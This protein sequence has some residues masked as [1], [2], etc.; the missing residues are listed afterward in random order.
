MDKKVK[1]EGF[2]ESLKG[3]GQDV[4]IESVKKG[5]RV[6]F[7]EIEKPQELMKYEFTENGKPYY[8]IVKFLRLA[9]D[10]EGGYR[11]VVEPTG[12]SNHEHFKQAGG[13]VFISSSP[14]SK[15]EPINQQTV[16]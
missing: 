7:E 9:Y 11:S 5:F 10:D 14:D 13:E 12:D 6:C 8:A 4:L 15:L 1:F 16:L 3:N 2:L